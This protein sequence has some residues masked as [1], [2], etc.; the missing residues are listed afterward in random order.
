MTASNPPEPTFEEKVL[1]RLDSVEDFKSQVIQSLDSVEDFKSQVIQ[2]LD[3]VEDFKSQV[4]QRLDK[5]ESR[6]L[7]DERAW[8]VVAFAGTVS[9]GLS[10]SAAIA[11]LI[12]TIKAGL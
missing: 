12:L 11:L 2:S 5:I 10:V 6:D 7:W 8:R 1:S 4:I 3:S 9:T